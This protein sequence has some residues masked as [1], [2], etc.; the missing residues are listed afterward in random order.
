MWFSVYELDMLRIWNEQ[1]WSDWLAGVR[2]W[3]VPVWT[4]VESLQQV[5]SAALFAFW[6]QRFS[7]FS[8]F[9][10]ISY[11][12]PVA[13]PLYRPLVKMRRH[14]NA[15]NFRSL[16]ASGGGVGALFWCCG[17]VCKAK[18]G[19]NIKNTLKPGARIQEQCKGAKK[20]NSFL[21][22]LDIYIYFFVVIAFTLRSKPQGLQKQLPLILMKQ[23]PFSPQ[24]IN[25]YCLLLLDWTCITTPKNWKTPSL[26]PP[27][28][29][30]WGSS[31]S[32][33]ADASCHPPPALKLLTV[34]F[35]SS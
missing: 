31:D 25:Y 8:A 18:R 14:R 21:F 23:F 34:Q 16:D 17:C 6:Y 1:V 7:C 27:Y 4:V 19:H 35:W 9:H 30:V 13:S 33:P 12:P 20:Q 3:L 10:L 24:M 28:F 22:V 15:L 5:P 29:H 32:W 11:S 2:W 26:L